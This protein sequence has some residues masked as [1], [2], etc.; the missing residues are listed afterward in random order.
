MAMKNNYWTCSKFADWLRGTAKPFAASSEEWRDWKRQAKEA[1]PFRYWLADE[2]LNHI[3]DVVCYVP[4]KANDIRY[5]INNRWVDKSHALVSHAEHCKRGEWH[6]VGHRMLPCLF[7]ELVDY[8][9]VEA[10]WHHVAWDKD[11]AKK[12]GRPW[13]RRW[14]R[15]WRCPEAGIENLEWSMVW[16]SIVT[17]NFGVSDIFCQKL[18]LFKH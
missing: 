3:Q 7:S 11:A 13:W 14:Y 1:H 9:E 17:L 8:V 15:N 4:N 10:A 5:Y 2:G 12:Y 16:L 6:N 18:M